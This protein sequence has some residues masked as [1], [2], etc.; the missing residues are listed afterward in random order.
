MWNWAGR[1]ECAVWP[2]NLVPC[3]HNFGASTASS[4]KNKKLVEYFGCVCFSERERE[5][6]NHFKDNHIKIVC[7]GALMGLHRFAF[8]PS[9]SLNSERRNRQKQRFAVLLWFSLDVFSCRLSPLIFLLQ[10][11]SNDRRTNVFPPP[12]SVL[13]NVASPSIFA[14]AKGFV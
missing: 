11:D 10:R 1:V 3:I 6:K 13:F 12:L 4:F 8:H 2:L 7:K 14:L 9:P 5:K